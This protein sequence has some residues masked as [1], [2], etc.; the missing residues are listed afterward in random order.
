MTRISAYNTLGQ[1]TSY[2]DA[3]GTTATY[4]YEKEGDDRLTKT[5]DGKGTQTHEYDKTT[6]QTTALKDSGA[7]T[8]SAT[9][10]TEGQRPRPTPTA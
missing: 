5:N 2:T 1:L 10:N 3:A 4:E 6:G 8:F 7:G 9:Y